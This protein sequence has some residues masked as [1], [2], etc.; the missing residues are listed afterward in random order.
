MNDVGQAAPDA[1]EPVQAAARRKKVAA[2]LTL[3]GE[4]TYELLKGLVSPKQP[5]DC[6]FEELQKAM[7]D[8]LGRR[9]LVV[10]ERFALRNRR[11]GEGGSV[12]DYAAAL[13][14][15]A[16]TC[17]YGAHLIEAL[18]DQFIRGLQS[19]TMQ[20]ELLKEDRDFADAVKHARALETAQHGASQFRQGD[21]AMASTH[22]VRQSQ[23]NTGK[24]ATMRQDL[25]QPC[26]RCG[27]KNH[28]PQQCCFKDV[29]CRR[30]GG[31][32]HI[33]RVC[34][35]SASD[36]KITPS[37]QGRSLQTT[38]THRVQEEMYGATASGRPQ[39]V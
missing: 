5:K 2:L 13:Q 23:T 27:G 19:V 22:S 17:S 29:E 11:Q 39:S 1:S 33:A 16:S 18:R 20:E 31:K 3:V 12:A 4:E 9:R 30:C 37:G 34:R 25:S 36:K 38:R 24:S 21:Q 14:K 15:M 8:H 7:Q 10:T 32:G 35:S 6:S 26:F 28:T